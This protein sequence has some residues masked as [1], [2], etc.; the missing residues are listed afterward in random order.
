MSNGRGWIGITAALFGLN[1][2]IGVLFTGLFFGFADAFAIRLQNVTDIPPNLIQ[3]LPHLTTLLVLVIMALR[4]RIARALVRRRSIARIK[5][6]QVGRAPAGAGAI[7][8]TAATAPDSLL[9]PP[10]AEG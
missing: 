2:P 3:I 6:G 4:E 9:P 5:A 1:H 8:E 7:S 10:S